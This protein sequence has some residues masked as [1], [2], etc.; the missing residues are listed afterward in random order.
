[1]R[2]ILYTR[3][4]ES[5]QFRN[6]FVLPPLNAIAFSFIFE[7][8]KPCNSSKLPKELRLSICIWAFCDWGNGWQCWFWQVGMVGIEENLGFGNED[9]D[10]SIGFGNWG[11]G[12]Y[13]GFGSVGNE[14]NG[15]NVNFDNVSNES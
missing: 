3:N 9:K 1:M 14:G 15:S 6:A 7:Y 8:C 2:Y 13:V 10:G 4:K 5:P 12:W 11:K